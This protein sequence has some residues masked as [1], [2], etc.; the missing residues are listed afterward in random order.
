LGGSCLADRLSHHI[1]LT[2]AEHSALDRLEEQQRTYRRG[3][4]ILAEGR[5]TRDVFVVRSGWLQTSLL[6]G[7]GGRQ[8]LRINL[9]GE[10]IGLSAL[11]FDEA[12]ETITALTDVELCPI[13]R[14]KLSDLFS[15]HPRVM[16]LLFAVSIAER[17]TLAD[18]L[19]S[20]G[21]TSARA[22]VAALL[23]DIFTRMELVHPGTD[24]VTIPLT[25]EEIGDATG[26]T[27]VHVNRM[28]RMLV[29]EGIIERTGHA[30]RL[31]DR[32][33]LDKEASYTERA[34]I[35]TGWLPEAS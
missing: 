9:P 32:R 35:T 7:N 18:R 19:A 8:I 33:R 4:V 10:L 17:T 16:A 21:R 3:A 2:P 26:L 13:D 23:C 15:A 30:M 22:R 11:A 5:P 20:V 31:L 34:P 25:Q 24:T 12:P 27:S 1:V 6:L 29:D 28:I 14:D